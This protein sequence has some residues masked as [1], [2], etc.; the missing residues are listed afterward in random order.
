MPTLA[1]DVV[2][3][4]VFLRREFVFSSFP[5]KRRSLREVHVKTL[6]LWE[7]WAQLLGVSRG[8]GVRFEHPDRSITM[9]GDADRR[10]FPCSTPR[11]FTR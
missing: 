9:E 6:P 1:D 5:E 8:A 10:T 2:L 11:L 3:R 4:H 7:V